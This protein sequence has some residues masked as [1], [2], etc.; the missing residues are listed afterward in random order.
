M[1]QLTDADI[2]NFALNLEYLEAEFYTYATTGS[3]IPASL[4]GTGSAPTTGGMMANLSAPI[5]VSVCRPS[6][7]ALPFSHAQGLGAQERCYDTCA[8]KQDRIMSRAMMSDGVCR[9]VAPLTR[10][11][12]YAL[13]SHRATL[14]IYTPAW[15]IVVCRPW[16]R[17]LRPMR[18]RTSPS[19]A[20]PSALPPSRSPRC[21]LPSSIEGIGQG[22][23]CC[24]PALELVG[25][26]NSL[27]G[28]AIARRTVSARP[29]LSRW[30]TPW[31]ASL[32][33]WMNCL[34]SRRTTW[35]NL[36]RSLST[37]TMP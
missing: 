36:S 26:Q 32:G 28:R 30:T 19:C 29:H 4:M 20:Q 22:S 14:P 37:R 13:L 6:A 7:S 9:A 34:V 12:S 17:R 8:F 10:A 25:E 15:H 31:C 23:S 35:S 2:L 3:G 21:G 11:L 24:Q 27:L 18:S 1:L 16:P 5:Q 33:V